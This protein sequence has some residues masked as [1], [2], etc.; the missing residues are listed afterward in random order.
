MKRT[1][2]SWLTILMVMFLLAGCQGPSDPQP[3]PEPELNSE[4]DIT[5]FSFQAAQNDVFTSDIEAM[6]SGTDI[7][8][9]LPYSTDVSALVANFTTTGSSVSIGTTAQVSGTT[10]N[11]FSNPLSYIVTAEDGSTK[12]YQVTVSIEGAD[13]W[14]VLLNGGFNAGMNHWVPWID[15]ESSVEAEFTIVDGALC[16][17]ILSIG[18]DP[19]QIDLSQILT[20]QKDKTYVVSFDVWADADRTAGVNVTEYNNDRDGDGDS[21]TGY[22]Q[23]ITFDVSQTRKTISYEFSML[24]S[25]DNSGRIYFRFGS[26]SSNVYMDNITLT[27]RDIVIPAAGTEMIVNGDMSD[28]L[29]SWQTYSQNGAAVTMADNSEV[30]HASISSVGTLSSDGQVSQ[31]YPGLR[32]VDSKIYSVSFDAWA[33]SDRSIDFSVWENGHDQNQNGFSWNP[34]SYTTHDITTTSAN[35]SFEFTMSGTN[36]DAGICFF[37]GATLGDVYIDNVSLMEKP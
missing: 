1:Y 18:S 15:E 28:G 12:E 14:G 16:I 5:S 20:L 9:T 30:L 22:D 33:S 37:I 7:S 36:L 13:A 6:V 17:D 3:E 26:S 29:T 24:N 4:K 23:L 19:W 25:T 11:D 21:Y 8:F 35:Y 10:A 27:E 2:Y 31:V 32:L 34:Y